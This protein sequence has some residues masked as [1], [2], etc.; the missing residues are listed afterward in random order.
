[1]KLYKKEKKF[2]LFG[3]GNESIVFRN[4]DE[5]LKIFTNHRH[6][7]NKVLKLP[8]LAELLEQDF[9][10]PLYL[11]QRQNEIIGYVMPYFDS[12]T[13]LE[14]YCK[15]DKNPMVK[16]L[17]YINRFENNIRRAHEKGIILGDTRFHNILINGDN[18][19]IIDVDNYAPLGF[20]ND[21][22]CPEFNEVKNKYSG[23]DADLYA[24]SL[25]LIKNLFWEKEVP[26]MYVR[27][28]IEDIIEYIFAHFE[29]GENFKTIFAYNL[30]NYS[31]LKYYGESIYEILD[32]AIK[33]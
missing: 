11:Y 6:L 28:D 16:K 32:N 23:L 24:F 12:T 7:K 10:K 14:E 33:R 1:M 19:G 4:E 21:I 13:N 15:D 22:Y 31:E 20:A 3:E 9:I 27:S 25:N 5:V 8:I 26:R 18:I 29:L 17:Y 30:T 2:R